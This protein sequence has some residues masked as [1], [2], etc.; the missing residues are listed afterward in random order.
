[1]RLEVLT[2]ADELQAAFERHESI[3]RIHEGC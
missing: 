2:R 1:V 3:I